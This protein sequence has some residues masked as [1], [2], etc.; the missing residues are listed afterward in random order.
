MLPRLATARSWWPSPL[1][2]PTATDQGLATRV[3]VRGTAVVVEVAHRQ[4]H[5]TGNSGWR[6]RRRC[7]APTAVA[8]QHRDGVGAK[9][10]DR[11]IRYLV[12][13]EV[14][15]GQGNGS[16]ANSDRYRLGDERSPKAV[17]QYHRDGAMA[18]VGCHAG[19][20]GD[21]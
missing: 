8:H 13:V 19:A 12:A 3:E 20:V 2:S 15:D 14:A 6:R 10:G 16:A 1:K 18:G 5:G 9:I 17:A 4:G 11:Q 21:C 7:E